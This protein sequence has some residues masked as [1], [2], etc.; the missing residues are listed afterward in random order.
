MKVN[1]ENIDTIDMSDLPKEKAF[2]SVEDV[3]D[4]LGVNYQL[5]YR[6]VRTGALPAMRVGRIYRIRRADLEAYIQRNSTGAVGGFTCGACGQ[7]YA[8]QL[9]RRGHCADTGQPICL[10]CWDRRGIRSCLDEREP[11]KS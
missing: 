4:F 5:I 1:K 2:W 10:D 7:T 9:S 8:S 3:A 11:K 6:Q